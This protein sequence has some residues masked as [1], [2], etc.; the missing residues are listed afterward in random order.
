MRDVLD[1][2]FGVE[3]LKAAAAELLGTALLTL[4]ALLAGTPYAV[5]LTLT[6][7]VYAI[8]NLSGCHVNP[9]VTLGL[10]AAGRL[11]VG[12]GLLYLVAQVAG[13]GAAAGLASRI[14]PLAAEYHA[15]PPFAELVGV[16]V[17]ML[18]VAAVSEQHVPKAGSGIAIGAALGAGLL[19]TGGILNPAVAVAMGQAWSAALWAPVAGG[20]LFATGFGVLSSGP[21]KGPGRA[22]HGAPEPDDDGEEEEAPSA[23][24]APT[25]ATGW[26]ARP[27]VGAALAARAPAP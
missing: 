5:A 7:L 3:T 12:K 8:S 11:P 6:A 10:V 21:V 18:T 4:A 19:T 2:V 9:A 25:P 17:L 20:V 23:E 22:K 1:D 13:A 24:E 14:G 15:A 16:G 26:E 27:R